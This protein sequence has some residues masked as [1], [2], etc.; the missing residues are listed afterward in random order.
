MSAEKP[1]VYTL[2]DNLIPEAREFV[3]TVFSKIKEP[4][5][6]ETKYGHSAAGLATE[7]RNEAVMGRSPEQQREFFREKAKKLVVKYGP[8]IIEKLRDE[9]KFALTEEDLANV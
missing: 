5:I 3:A 9:L 7:L 4:I 2:P 8:G 1:K 6:Q